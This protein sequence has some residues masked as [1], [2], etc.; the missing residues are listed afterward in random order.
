LSAVGLVVG[1]DRPAPA[2]GPQLRTEL[3]RMLVPGMGLALPRR[4]G[5]QMWLR[6]GWQLAAITSCSAWCLGDWLVYGQ[7]SYTG[8]YRD[9]IEQT[10]LDYQ[11]LRNY[12]WVARRFPLSRRRDSVSFGH[13]AEVAAL[14][15]SEQDF[16]LRKAAELGW[17]RN[18]LRREVRASLKQRTP[19]PAITGPAPSAQP[20]P[21]ASQPTGHMNTVL[22]QLTAPQLELCRQAA[23]RRH[24]SLEAWAAQSLGQAA[25]R[26]TRDNPPC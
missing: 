9:A 26:S 22:V 15:E 13:H 20:P 16:W 25:H 4:L 5:F 7:A 19:S 18:H 14:P 10:G 21:D 24:L 11:T 2:A 12:A 3:A 8:R 6:I 17:S 23:R 1:V